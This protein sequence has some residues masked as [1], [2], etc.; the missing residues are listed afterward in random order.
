[1]TIYPSDVAHSLMRNIHFNC[2]PKQIDFKL[3][4]Y[5]YISVCLHVCG[6]YVFVHCNQLNQFD[7]GI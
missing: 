3:N 4:E 7:I 6:L 2:Q 1:M 5:K